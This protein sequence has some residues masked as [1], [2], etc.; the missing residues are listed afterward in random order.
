MPDGYYAFTR[1]LDPARGVPVVDSG[2]WASGSPMAE[3]IVRVLRT[4]KGSYRADPSFGVDYSDIDK[5]APDAP[6]RLQLAIEAALAVYVRDRLIADLRVRVT[7]A[8]SQIRYE[9][10]FSDPRIPATQRPI[11]GAL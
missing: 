6:T 4:P 8:G 5:G 7:R 9:V 11:R 2:T 10:S 3:V 1:K